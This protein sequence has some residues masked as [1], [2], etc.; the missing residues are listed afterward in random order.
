MCSTIA[1][2]LT[3]EPR[4]ARRDEHKMNEHFGGSLVAMRLTA[5]LRKPMA[6]QSVAAFETETKM[7]VVVGD[8]SDGRAVR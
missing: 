2:R 5:C 1:S 3:I 7:S 6:S 8:C 4:L